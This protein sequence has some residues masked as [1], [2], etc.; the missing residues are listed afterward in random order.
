MVSI[1]LDKLVH[2]AVA[3][4]GSVEPHKPVGLDNLVGVGGLVG[5]DQSADFERAAD[6]AV[7]IVDSGGLGRLI[8]PGE[9]ADPDKLVRLGKPAD[10]AAV[11]VDFVDLDNL[12]DL[13]GAVV[14][15]RYDSPSVHVV[16]AH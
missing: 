1:G 7:V 12:V 13:I 15:S 10:P 2:L 14:N 4:V 3:I 8:G 9:F 11:I 5:P 6:L 16:V